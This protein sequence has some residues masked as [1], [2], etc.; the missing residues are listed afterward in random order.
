MFILSSIP[1]GAMLKQLDYEM[2][3]G[4][5]STP[6]EKNVGEPPPLIFLITPG[7]NRERTISAGITSSL[8]QKKT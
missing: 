1:G 2:L 5:L 3:L 6:K 4:V 8:K 7:C